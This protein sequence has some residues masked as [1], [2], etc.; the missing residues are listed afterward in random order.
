MR[1]VKFQKY[2]GG[3]TKEGFF[4][5]WMRDADGDICAVV[6]MDDGSVDMTNAD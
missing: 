1:R 4:H 6:E 3:L 2:A 5:Q